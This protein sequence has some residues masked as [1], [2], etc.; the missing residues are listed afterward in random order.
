M[1]NNSRV[2]LA[3]AAAALLLLFVFPLWTIRLQAPQY[4]EGLGL[5]I[6]INTIE[7]VGPNDLRNINGLNHYIGMK[8]IEPDAIPELRFM[9]WIVVGLAGLGLA[10]AASGRRSALYVWFALLAILAVAGM[11]DFWLWEYDYGHNLDETAAIK[12]PGMSYQPPL[13]GSKRLLNFTATSWPGIGGWIAFAVGALGAWLV[14]RELRAARGRRVAAT[15][16]VSARQTP[17]PAAAV[18]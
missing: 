12:V 7:G 15:E 4:P 5:Q 17:R 9:P 13:I 18:R 8:K 6:R 10:A 1:S 2:L 3:I 11:V 16:A 14:F